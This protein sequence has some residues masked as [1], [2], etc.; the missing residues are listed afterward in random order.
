MPANEP[1][2][3]G[4]VA[5]VLPAFAN[6]AHAALL[7]PN[8]AAESHE[9]TVYG[10]ASAAPAATSDAQVAIA[11]TVQRVLLRGFAVTS[12]MSPIRRA[13][14]EIAPRP[15]ACEPL[16]E[17]RL[18]QHEWGIKRHW[19]ESSNRLNS[20][21]TME[22]SAWTDERIDDRMTAIDANFD[23]L[24]AELRELRIEI[25]TEIAGIRHDLAEF[26]RQVTRIVGGF[27]IGLLAF[28]PR[29]S[30]S[31]SRGRARPA[32]AVDQPAVRRTGGLH[33]RFRE[34]RVRVDDPGDL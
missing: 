27:A 9:T 5:Y 15:P 6:G 34:R 29:P 12:V 3:D 19:G 1:P 10:R 31:S 7:C 17:H 22:R 28:W 26:Q 4:H 18:A 11:V 2:P 13:G 25:R 23:R 32:L 16:Q 8:R 24:F 30:S 14:D 21:V 20:P 33:D